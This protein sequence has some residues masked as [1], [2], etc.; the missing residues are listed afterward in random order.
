MTHRWAQ[1]LVGIAAGIVVAA[2]G[3][4]ALPLAPRLPPVPREDAAP[5]QPVADPNA[6]AAALLAYDDIV[7]HD[8]FAPGRKPP[9]ERY[10]PPELR[11]RQ[12]ARARTGATP[13]PRLLGVATGPAGAVA[14][15]D[16]D[17][18]IPGAEIYRLGDRVGPYRLAAIADSAV[19]L[20]GASGVHTL[21]LEAHI[22]RA[23]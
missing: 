18:A 6:E 2:V 17:P 8:P 15:I 11:A 23:R 5:A 4:Q 9:A 10:V 12:A 3:W 14:L 22:G 16:A 7:R 1:R 19:V 21:R 20:R 13:R